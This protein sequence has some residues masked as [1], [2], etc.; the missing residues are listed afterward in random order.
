MKTKIHSRCS[1]AP[2]PAQART[3]AVDLRPNPQS[4]KPM[5]KLIALLVVVGLWV[6]APLLQA[7]TIETYTFTTNR[8]V[9]DGNAAGLSDVRTLHSAIGNITG[10]TVG[11]KLTGE[12]N[13]DLYVYLRHASGYTVLLNRPGK[14]AGNAV[15]YADSGFNVTFQDGAANGD[16]HLYENVTNPAAGTP[17]T[18]LWQPDGRTNDPATV[19]DAAARTTTLSNF[20]GLN[21]AGEWT[22]YVSDLQSG[23]TN[24]VTQWSLQITGASYPTLTWTNPADITYG[25]ALSGTQLNAVAVYNATNVAGTYSYTPAAGTVLNAGASQTLAVTFTPAD[26]TSFL[27]VSTNVAINV[28]T[29]PLTITAN[30]TNKV[31][32]ANVPAF[33]ASY[34]GLVN[35]DS[36]ASLTTPVVLQSTVSSASP[37]GLYAITASGATS[38]NYTITQVGGFLTNTPAALVITANN[39]NM[40][41]GATVPAF[42]ASYSGFTNGDSPASLTT[43]VALTSAASSASP[44]GPYAITPSGAADTNYAIS[45]VNGTLT[46]GT[47]TLT[48]TANSQTKA[49]GAALPVLTATY[50]GWVNGDTTNNL[51][52]LAT[53]ATTATATSDPG[54]YPI[55]A[56]NA[57][58][59]N[60]AFVYVPGTLTVTNSWTT[61]TLASSANPALPGAS[62]TFTLTVAA[63]AP[64]VGTPTGTVNFRID[65]SVAGSGTL[66][67]GVATYSTS[68][69]SHGTHTVV[70]E[71]AGSTDFA[72]A[73]NTLS[74]VQTINTPPVAGN[75]T[76]SRALTVGVKFRIADLL[77]NATDADGDPLTVVL[78]SAS[79]NSGTITTNNG[80]VFYAPASGYTNAD[81]FTYTVYD[82]YGGSATGTVTV[83]V[84]EDDAAGQNLVI[85]ALGGG[86]YR[87][88]GSGIPGRTY[89]MQYNDALTTTPANWLDLSGGSVTADLTGAFQYTDTAGNSGRAYRSVYP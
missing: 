75:E 76:V 53:L 48:V 13:G 62:V 35:G 27:A 10:L 31:Y 64:G 56:T 25:T 81:S 88:D 28:L 83:N 18:G 38:T 29:A 24:L 70:A 47:A 14:T 74:P 5:P 42:T 58:S 37:V 49:Y 3:E 15:G 34:S 68:S 84:L 1:F 19:T 7:Q 85:T 44:A 8:L 65:G 87:I 20:N 23:G 63:V 77:T 6:A 73:T 78:S 26:T 2:L 61:G 39:T 89:R 43:P 67:S 4:S 79:A 46:I 86:S 22:L 50:S 59:P 60:Y 82:G 57:A 72:G 54:A 12:F 17:L 21:A 32:G 41:Y 51:T 45:Y 30:N 36:A 9:P 66:A 40:V 71:Y 16:V 69:L 33:T 55:T 11:F 80:W 52:A